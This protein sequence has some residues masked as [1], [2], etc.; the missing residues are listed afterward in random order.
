MSEEISLR[1]CSHRISGRSAP[2][3]Q[4]E[5]RLAIRARRAGVRSMDS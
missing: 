5:M 2:A 1:T 4:P 3:D